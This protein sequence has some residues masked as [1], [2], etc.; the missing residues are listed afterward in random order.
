M[1]DGIYHVAFSSGSSSFGEGIAV[2]KGD[3]VNGGDHGYTYSGTKSGNGSS[4]TSTLTIKRWNPSAQSI[5]GAV[6]EFSL[7]LSGSAS[8]ADG[9]VAQGHV[10]GQP[11][12]RIT[13]RGKYLVAAA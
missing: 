10:V 8:G 11:Q 12:L 1:L 2:F 13:I 7:E 5:F 6:N 3:S 9:F 4:F